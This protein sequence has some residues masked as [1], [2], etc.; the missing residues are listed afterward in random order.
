MC[1]GVYISTDSKQDLTSYNTD[2]LRFEKVADPGSDPCISLL[3]YASRW[4]VGSKSGCSC[5]FRHLMSID[6]GFSEPVDWY[7]EDQEELDATV[8]L[9]AAL[10]S[11]LTS[12]HQ[13]E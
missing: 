2:L 7:K 13:V 10:D 12:G 11:L 1:Y 5:T 8:E 9:Y 4:Y 6:L 3:E